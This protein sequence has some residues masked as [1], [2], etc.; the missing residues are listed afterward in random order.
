MVGA[1]LESGGGGRWGLTGLPMWVP[2][3][4]QNLEHVTF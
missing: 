3:H 2:Q 4:I 1:L